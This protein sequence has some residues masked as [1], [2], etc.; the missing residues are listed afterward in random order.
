[1][2]SMDGIGLL[3]PIENAP[4]PLLS[5]SKYEIKETNDIECAFNLDEEFDV[6]RSIN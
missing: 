4:P 1:M 2:D 5:S 3:E 6:V